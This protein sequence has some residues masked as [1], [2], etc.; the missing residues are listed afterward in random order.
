MVWTLRWAPGAPRSPPGRN[1]WSPSPGCWCGTCAWWSWTRRPPGWT[2]PPNAAWSP[3]RTGRTGILIAHRLSTTQR[4]HQ[5][6]VL[7][8]GRIL[9]QGRRAELAAAE[10]P[11]RELL[12]AA[13]GDV[14]ATVDGAGPG[15]AG[16]AGVRADAAGAQ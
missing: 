5:V 15:D 13:G 2:R 12:A 7:A 1:S 14:G 10:G 6:A 3:L 9:Q 11:F 16:S 8:G 4:A